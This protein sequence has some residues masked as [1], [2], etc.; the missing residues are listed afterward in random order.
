MHMPGGRVRTKLARRFPNPI[1]EDPERVLINA[2]C[3]L[4][5]LGALLTVRPGS[6]LALWPRWVAVEWAV[7]ML[8]GGACALFGFLRGKRSMARLGY[9]L[10]AAASV[11]YGVGVMIVFGWQGLPPGLIFIGLAAAKVIRLLVGS[12]RRRHILNG[13]STQEPT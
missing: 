8:V 9:L 4:I 13:G 10:I 12:A 3:V 11:V 1:L 6:L 5:G 2:A 7:A